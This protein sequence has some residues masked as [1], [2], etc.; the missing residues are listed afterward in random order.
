MS[1]VHAIGFIA[2]YLAPGVVAAGIEA[3]RQFRAEGRLTH[4]DWV[5]YELLLEG[6]RYVRAALLG[7]ASGIDQFRLYVRRHWQS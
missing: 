4:W 5:V 1:A 6:A 3:R 2:A 7:L